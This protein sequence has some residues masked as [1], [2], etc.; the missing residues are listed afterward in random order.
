MYFNQFSIVQSYFSVKEAAKK[1]FQQNIISVEKNPIWGRLQ[2][3]TLI[4]HENNKFEE[5][6]GKNTLTNRSSPR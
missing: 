2:Y 1:S 3:F 4:V 5:N 6:I